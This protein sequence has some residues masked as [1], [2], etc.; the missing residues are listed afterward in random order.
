MHKQK[1]K[2]PATIKRRENNRAASFSLNVMSEDD[3]FVVL[4]D[5]T[6]HK[7]HIECAI[8]QGHSEKMWKKV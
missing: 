3:R 6:S 2:R 5:V 1:M 7:S 8:S 4:C